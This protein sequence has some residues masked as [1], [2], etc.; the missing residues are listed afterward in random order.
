MDSLGPSRF[1]IFEIYWRFCE[2]RT[3]NAYVCGEEGYRQD[4]E[5]QRSKLSR[6]ALNQLLK[7][8]ESRMITRTAIFDELLKL[9]LQLDLTENQHHN[10]S[11]DTW[12]QVLAFSRCVHE[13]LEGYD[14]EGA[15]PVL[16]DDFVEHMY[17]LSGSNKDSNVF[18]SCGDSEYQLCADED[19]LPGLR[20]FPG[21]K[22]KLPECPEDEMESLD[23]HFSI[24]PDLN[25]TL[26]SKRSRSIAHR[27]AKREDN[28]PQNS[29]DDC[30]EIV[31]HSSPMGSSK[32]LC[33]IEGYLSKGFAGL[34]SSRSYF[35]V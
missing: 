35:A 11:E 31:K 2:L 23:S 8:V 27:S 1:D 4:D 7:M 19:T 20:V 22:R 21:L 25:C 26:N 15:W 24:S 33:A 29:S 28:T 9:M 34:L 12:Q 32:S 10:V 17:R 18:C 13:N 3:G 14:P 16:I 6:E 30:M 5:S